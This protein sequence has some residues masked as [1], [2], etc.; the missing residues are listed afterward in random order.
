[1]FP[2]VVPLDRYLCSQL[3][4]L[5]RN[6]STYAVNEVECLLKSPAL[7]QPTKMHYIVTVINV[8][9]SCYIGVLDIARNVQCDFVLYQ[10]ASIEFC[11]ELDLNI[12]TCL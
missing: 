11:F 10:H 1:V 3:S 12:P 8:G 4:Y 6:P 2:I 7:P 5:Q 9:L